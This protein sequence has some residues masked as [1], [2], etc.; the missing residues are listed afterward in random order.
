MPYVHII[1]LCCSF[2]QN[3]S[4]SR[5]LYALFIHIRKRYFIAN[6]A[7]VWLYNCLSASEVT[8]M[9]MGKIEWGCTK[10]GTKTSY[11]IS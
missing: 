3:D 2:N 6:G 4:N 5:G 1:Y 9:Q 10:L 11:K 7:I 8:L